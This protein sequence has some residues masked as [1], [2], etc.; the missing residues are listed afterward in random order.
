MR[1]KA[2][3]KSKWFLAVT[4]GA[5]VLFGLCFVPGRAFSAPI[6]LRFTSVVTSLHSDFKAFQAFADEVGKK[7]GG[8]VHIT[9]Y[10]SG[11]LNPPIETYNAIKTGM[12][13]MGCAPVGYSGPIL[14]LNHLFGDA[15][16]GLPTSKEAAKAYATALK[17]VPEMMAEFEGMHVVYVFCTV[18]LSIGTAKKPVRKFDDFKGLVMRFP[19]G[20]ETVARAWG[21]SPVAVPVGDI[22]VALQKG[23]INGFMGGAEM[24]KAMRLA[25]LTKYVTSA[26]MTYGFN[27][28]AV[29]K[30]TWDSFPA[31]VKKVFDDLDDWALNMTLEH[32]DQSEKE[33]KAYAKSQGTQEIVLDKAELNKLWAAAKPVFEKRA[34][35]LESRGK[36]GKKVLTAVDKL[37]GK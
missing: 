10:P 2:V 7:T 19:P 11:T 22:Y 29:N 32:L 30:K 24:L 17:T 27:Y 35:D 33:S 23:T 15:L 21:A 26:Q 28:V 31:D 13:Q 12:A 3:G 8:K 16:R 20:M 6:E 1:G 36:A 18:P 25:E 4:I 9:V 5:L 14:P 37:S 34:A